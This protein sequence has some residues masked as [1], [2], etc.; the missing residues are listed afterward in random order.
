MKD[1]SLK[2][3]AAAF[4]IYFYLRTWTVT[5]DALSQGE[6]TQLYI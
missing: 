2:L 6:V 1:F 4:L 5:L 3:N